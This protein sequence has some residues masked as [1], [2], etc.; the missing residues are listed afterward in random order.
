MNDHDLEMLR[1][2]QSLVLD[3]GP[4]AL[5]RY[6]GGVGRRPQGRQGAAGNQ[7]AGQATVR[8]ETHEETKPSCCQHQMSMPSV[9]TTNR[10]RVNELKQPVDQLNESTSEIVPRFPR[11]AD[12]SV[13]QKGK[14]TLILSHA[15]RRGYIYK[16]DHGPNEAQGRGAKC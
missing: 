9:Q 3:H 16:C 8:S 1:W 12:R 14:H 4:V 6:H 2:E 10:T 7:A 11:E 15:E 5:L 13:Y